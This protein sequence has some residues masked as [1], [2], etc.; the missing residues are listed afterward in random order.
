MVVDQQ[1]HAHGFI[2]RLAQCMNGKRLDRLAL[3]ARDRARLVLHMI[4]DERYFGRLGVITEQLQID[5]R[6]PRGRTA[7]DR[8]S[9]MR[10]KLLQPVHP[11][12]GQ[13]AQCLQLL[14]L[15]VAAEQL[16]I[17]THRFF[18]L[19]VVGQRRAAGQAKLTHGSLLGRTPFEALL[20]HQ[21]GRCLS[22][23]SSHVIQTH[24]AI[25]SRPQQQARRVMHAL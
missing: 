6:Q 12:Q 7:P 22:D 3:K 15:G 4:V 18:K 10:T 16:Y 20:H 1:M 21:A 19:I 11:E 14:R 13:L 9:Q 5:I 24:S 8:P 23:F 25:S 17:F 2:D